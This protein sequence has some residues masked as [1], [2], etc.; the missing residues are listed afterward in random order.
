MLYMKSLFSL[1]LAILLPL[2]ASAY[3]FLADG[4]AYNVSGTEA[5]VTFK[6]TSYN[7]YSGSVAIPSTVTNTNNGMTYT[8]T[9]IGD[10]AFNKCT[11]LTSVSIPNTIIAIGNYAF[12]GCS[13]LISLSI[14][15]SV[16]ALGDYVFQKSG[17]TSISIPNSVTTIGQ[18]A[19]SSCSYLA[20]VEIPNSVTSIGGYVFQNC[21]RLTSVTIPSSI[22]AISDNAFYGCT[23]LTNV[24]IPSTVT[25]IGKSSF[26]NCSGLTNVTIPN[27]VNTI[28][29][30]AFYGCSGLTHVS[31][32]N[33]VTTIGESAFATCS[34]LNDFII[35]NAVTTIGISAFRNCT[36]LTRIT[37]P[38]SITRINN[39]TFIGC[40]SL[41]DVTIGNAVESIGSSAFSN[42]SSL[43]NITIPNS[44]T[45]IE[46]S[47]FM[48]CTSLAKASIGNSVTTIGNSAFSGCTALTSITIPKSV[49]S[50]EYS[51]FYGCTSLRSLYFNAENCADL[52]YNYSVNRANNTFWNC[53][54]ETIVIGDE[55]KRIPAYL[56]ATDRKSNLKT[57]IIGHSV[58]TIGQ[59]AFESCS[60]LTS[61]TLPNSIA[62]IGSNAFAGCTK[63]KTIY[64]CGE[65]EWKAGP[66]PMNTS[67][68]TL[69]IGSGITLLSDMKVNPTEIYCFAPVPPTCHSNSFTGY[70]GK[71][72]VPT[73]AFATY[74]LAP[75]WENFL[76]IVA[77]AVE[78]QTIDLSATTLEMSPNEQKT[79][80]ASLLPVEAYPDTITWMTSN[81]DIATVSNGV[82]T[83]VALGE[84]DIIVS[85]YPVT[86]VCHVIV[87]EVTPQVI[88]TLDQHEVS[89]QPN[90]MVLLTPT[91]TEPIELTVTSSDP[92]VVGARVVS[93]M[94]RIV[95]IRVGTAVVTVSSS[96]GLAQP[97]TCSV[98]VYSEPGDINAD[99]YINVTDITTLI[100]YLLTD[101]SSPAIDTRADVNGDGEVNITDVTM[102]INNV[103]NTD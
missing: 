82:I 14:P 71:L 51:A 10:N 73:M 19:F 29:N 60:G 13:G 27:S 3:S 76:D 44:V 80:T 46:N 36:A 72:H 6:T 61:L 92:T 24:T 42:C 20:S 56:N 33:A 48:N 75:T 74:C 1:L 16:T 89:L 23:G 25:T 40:T 66:L 94:V 81:P 50:I 34:Q 101:N 67:I 37:I 52:Y 17:L 95:A 59:K 98:I 54:L 58:T 103:L 9:A 53:P 64:I 62:T 22:T 32:G 57:L 88:I 63:L 38:N 28:G 39:S 83:A 30:T 43:T 5:T 90:H 97:D 2:S 87:R 93:G 11:G 96:D 15:N 79:L 65:G 70:N 100:S 8:V 35:P 77:E 91:T 31:I 41:K 86:A 12:S 49:T 21:T 55:V 18:Y 102:L 7:S 69:Y 4:I 47:A 85:C 26:Y 68:T 84:C 45:T 78:P 99:G